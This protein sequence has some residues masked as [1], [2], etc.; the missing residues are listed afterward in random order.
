MEEKTAA[1]RDPS[2]SR[3]HRGS[4]PFRTSARGFIRR[5]SP[6]NEVQILQYIDDLLIS[7][8]GQGQVRITSIPLLN[9]LGEKD[10]KVSR[11]K[12]QF[13][14]KEVTYLGH[15]IGEGYKKLS[16]ER[17][18]GSLS[19]PA[20]KT[21]RD[22]RKL[23]G[24]FRY[25]KLWLDKYTQ[26]VRF[27]YEKLVGS[28]PI[29]WTDTD[30]D[31]LGN[32]KDKLSSAP[33]LSLPDLGKEFDLF[34]NTEGGAAYGVLTQEWGGCRKPIAYLS[35]SLDPVARGWPTCLQVIAAAATLVEETQKLVLQGRVRVRT[36]HD[37]TTILSHKAQQWLT[38]SRIL[39]DEIILMNAN[40]LEL[41]TS[42]SLN[43]AQ[44]LSG[45]PLPE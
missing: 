10:L 13:V 44:F 32:L 20:P 23:L 18:S 41:V 6:K 9:F 4:K 28:E 30:E 22:V 35:K 42:R 38:D 26:S 29:N 1:K 14:E 2:P 33:I 37:L 15:I 34:I 5:V 17:I 12:L 7:G 19:I 45:N 8:K 3:F 39:K 40:D 16:P 24:L 11:N 31:Q 25:C 43:P 27:L 21:K 36:P